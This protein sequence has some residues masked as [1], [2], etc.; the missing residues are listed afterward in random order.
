MNHS[1]RR[2]TLLLLSTL[3]FVGSSLALAACGDDSG[4][5]SGGPGGAN[6]GGQGAGGGS[7]AE[8]CP[9][10]CQ[11]AGFD[12]GDEIDFGGGVIECTCEGT[13]SG[14][15]EEACDAYCDPFGIDPANA[16]LSSENS[17]NDKCVCDGTGS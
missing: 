13:G 3:T 1:A 16:L 10:L 12:D 5:G 6:G 17:A 11:G 8:G 15:T 7:S 2:L 9:G 14:I 4:T